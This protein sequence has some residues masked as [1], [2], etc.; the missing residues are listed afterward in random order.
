MNTIT[1]EGVGSIFAGKND[2][3]AA[4]CFD[5]YMEIVKNPQYNFYKKTIVW[6]KKI[7]GKIEL[8]KMFKPFED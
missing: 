7:N 1:L 2:Q 3:E 4:K 6:W 5:K 8:I